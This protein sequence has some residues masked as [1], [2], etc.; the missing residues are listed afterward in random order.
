MGRGRQGSGTCSRHF[1]PSRP[2]PPHRAPVRL[3][4]LGRF[5]KPGLTLRE[6]CRFG[7][8]LGM[9]SSVKAALLLFVFS[10]AARAAAP[11]FCQLLPKEGQPAFETF[12]S[13]A[14]ELK[15]AELFDTLYGACEEGLLDNELS[16]DAFRLDELRKRAPKERTE[17][18][19]QVFSFYAGDAFFQGVTTL[20]KFDLK[21]NVFR[22]NVRVRIQPSMLS[23]R[24]AVFT[25]T[26]PNFTGSPSTDITV[27]V[28]VDNLELAR[29]VEQE[30]AAGVP[31]GEDWLGSEVLVR[32]TGRLPVVPVALPRV[33]VRR[34]KLAEFEVLGF[35]IGQPEQ[36]VGAF[37]RCDCLKKPGSC[38]P[39]EPVAESAPVVPDTNFG[40]VA[41][42]RIEL[43][44]GQVSD[45][46]VEGF[47][48][49]RAVPD[50]DACYEVA[51]AGKKALH[52]KLVVRFTGAPNGRVSDVAIE[53]NTTGDAA[54]GKC[55]EARFRNL[56]HELA[57]LVGV[58]VA[59][60]FQLTPV[61]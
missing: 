28:R 5:R 51:L 34:L 14:I 36:W 10:S 23:D 52:G 40:G 32:P 35:R 11:S 26:K 21:K 56:K 43:E 3:R 16:C 59:A 46:D 8:F 13:A 44:S 37:M 24:Q 45:R 39:P 58:A 15:A 6:V 20:A 25:T 17:A 38:L 48:A 61:E 50:I 1:R 47:L 22:A 19:K 54:L 4:L 53:E 57:S 9:G 29:R 49:T 7:L 18:T 27:D 2:G 33:G 42:G 30:R 60:P 12:T 55:V 31:T 41:L